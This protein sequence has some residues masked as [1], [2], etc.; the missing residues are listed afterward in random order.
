MGR[1]EVA[2]N[3]ENH[4]EGELRRP[5]ELARRFCALHSGRER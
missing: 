2:L 4:E 5:P 1:T 3:I